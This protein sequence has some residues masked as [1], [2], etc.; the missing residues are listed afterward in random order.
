MIEPD[1]ALPRPRHPDAGA[2]APRRAR[3][4]AHAA[5]PRGD[6]AARRRAGLLLGRRAPVLAAPRRLHDRRRLR[7]R[8]HAEPDLRG[9]LL[10]LDRPHRGRARR[11]RPGEGLARRRSCRRSG[12]ATTRPRACARATTSAPSTA[13]RSTTLGRRSSAAVEA[14]RERYQAVAERRR[15]RRDHHRDRPGRR[16]STTPRTTTSSTWPRTRTATAASA[17]PA[18]PARSA[19]PTAAFRGRRIPAARG[20][21]ARGRTVRTCVRRKGKATGPPHRRSPP[22]QEWGGT[23]RSIRV[24]ESAA[25]RPRCRRQR[26][27]CAA[28]SASSRPRRDVDLR[29][30]HSNHQRA[31][32][33]GQAYPMPDS[34]DWLYVLRPGRNRVPLPGVLRRP[35][36]R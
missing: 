25:L 4:A 15:L 10:R 16:R 30:V 2:R 6:R 18:S 20:S 33:S 7:R 14:S 31:T 22:S 21:A 9:G 23:Y 32:L 13:R 11:V 35:S 5:V 26:E 36:P 24:T 34:Y 8:L 28:C 17:A 3:H 1:R 12:R 29:R 27:A 19:S